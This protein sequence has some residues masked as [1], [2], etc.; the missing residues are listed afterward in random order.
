MKHILT[1]LA[2]FITAAPALAHGDHPAA[3]ATYIANEGI[4]VAEGETK[5][6]F[7]PLFTQGYGT[8][9]TAPDDIRASM[10]AGAAPYD[11][12]DAIFIS[13]AHGDH[14]SGSDAIT[15]MRLNPDVRLIGPAQ[16]AEM[17]ED[18]AGAEQVM[19]RVMAVELEYDAPAKSITIGDVSAK[20]IRIP[21]AGGEG[22]REVQNYVWRVTLNDGVTVMHMGDADP[23]DRWFAPHAAHFE[24]RKTDTAF[25]PYWFLMTQ[26]GQAILNTRLNI[27]AVIGVHVPAKLPAEL[28]L[29]GLPFFHTPGETQAVPHRE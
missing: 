1:A 11:G 12:V 26:E 2:L 18:L 20:A 28:A 15:Y 7:D 6:L 25:P 10:F 16:M 5:V 14:F 23:A 24:A 8:Y 17:M 9:Q 29:S 4:M 27:G 19:S 22:R 21:H 3:E 13:H